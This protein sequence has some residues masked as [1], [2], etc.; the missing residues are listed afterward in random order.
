M[1]FVGLASSFMPYLLFV[2]VLF[3]LT[4]GPNI[5]T[6]PET[7]AL[8]EKTIN[9]KATKSQEL[10]KQNDCYFYALN[11]PTSEQQTSVAVAVPSKTEFTTY[12]ARSKT[13]FCAVSAEYHFKI[14]HTRF[15]LSPPSLIS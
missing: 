12:N 14:H 10:N 13:L 6:A 3:V 1:F 8:Q 11:E 15:G 9:Q 5:K 4:L 7:I 2:G